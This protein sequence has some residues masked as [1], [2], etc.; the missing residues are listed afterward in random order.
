[1]YTG[2]V[3]C[4]GLVNYS[5]NFIMIS[6]KEGRASALKLWPIIVA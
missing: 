4:S 3:G 5:N 2:P 1:M 6:H